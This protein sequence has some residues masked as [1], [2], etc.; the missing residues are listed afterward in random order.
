MGAADDGTVVAGGP[1]LSNCLYLAFL[2]LLARGI[3]QH[4]PTLGHLLPLQGT[5]YDPVSQWHNVYSHS[6][7]L[8]ITIF[9]TQRVRLLTLPD[10]APER[11]VQKAS[12]G[13]GST[14]NRSPP[15]SSRLAG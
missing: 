14:G 3:R 13:R 6:I 10:L 5:N 9:S 1:A 8:E 7:L 2:G 15:N 11:Q 4:D 12:P